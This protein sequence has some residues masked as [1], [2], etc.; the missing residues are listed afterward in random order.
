MCALQLR[1]SKHC[2]KFLGIL[3]QLLHMCNYFIL[4]LFC[5]RRNVCTWMM[6]INNVFCVHSLFTFQNT[7]E[8]NVVD[9][10]EEQ[11]RPFVDMTSSQMFLKM[12]KLTHKALGTLRYEVLSTSL[13]D[14]TGKDICEKQ[15]NFLGPWNEREKI[16]MDFP[17]S[18]KE[19]FS[20]KLNL[21]VL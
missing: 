10:K 18:F 2:W 19:V 13:N 4:V 15:S 16:A 5:A 14:F 7:L 6:S 3:L 1:L 17:N 11:S 21:W 9:E 20:C 8:N 12:R